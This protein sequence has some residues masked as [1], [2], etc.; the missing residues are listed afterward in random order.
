MR[1]AH[2]QQHRKAVETA[3]ERWQAEPQ[4]ATFK[5]PEHKRRCLRRRRPQFPQNALTRTRLSVTSSSFGI[6]VRAAITM[7]PHINFCSRLGM[8][9]C[10]LISHLIS[11]VDIFSHGTSRSMMWPLRPTI[12]T[13]GMAKL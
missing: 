4:Y 1:G 3:A 11:Q 10:F 9:V 12:V 13:V 2:L 8:P 5:Q 7:S 6:S